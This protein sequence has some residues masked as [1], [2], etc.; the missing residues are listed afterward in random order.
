MRI[1]FVVALGRAVALVMCAA[2]LGGC[3][4]S[5]PGSPS[6]LPSSAASKASPEQVSEVVN[7]LVERGTAQLAD[8]DYRAASVSL[9]QALDIDPDSIDANFAMA[10]LL[11]TV[12]KDGQALLRYSQ[13]LKTD[14]SNF[15]AVYNTAILMERS[16]VR[17]A[18]SL[19][20]RAVR[21]NPANAAAHIRLGKALQ[22]AGAGK[23]G[24]T[25]L[26][27]GYR[28]DPSLRRVK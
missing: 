22:K 17:A 7:A 15:A 10:Y 9:Q 26:R 25:A 6:T 21:L 13:V 18:I 12:G 20:R 5:A 14:S 3:T 24:A 28:L 4:A 27:E 2:A 19:Y 1:D 23:A 8:Q 16:N 11:Q